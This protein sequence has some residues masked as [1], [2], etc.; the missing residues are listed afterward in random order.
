MDLEAF[1][2]HQL[3]DDLDM[4]ETDSEQAL[5]A[6]AIASIALGAHEARRRRA[7]RRKPSRLYLCRAQ[8]LR[9]PR[10]TTPWQT[11]FRS[12]SDRAYITT[13]GFDVKTFHAIVSGGF[14]EAWNTLPIPRVTR[15]HTFP[16]Y[17]SIA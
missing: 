6:T 8:L 11:L 12:G 15:F 10:G 16:V 9:N 2:L 17:D 1:L 5:I 13:M 7:E 14:G 3:D 4:D